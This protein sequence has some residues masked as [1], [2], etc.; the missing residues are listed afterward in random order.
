ML[1]MAWW[2]LKNKR[3]HTTNT[4]DCFSIFHVW[5]CLKFLPKLSKPVHLF[6]YFHTTSPTRKNILS[7]T[8]F[9]ELTS[10]SPS[11]LSIHKQHRHRLPSFLNVCSSCF[12]IIYSRYTFVLPIAHSACRMMPH[13][14]NLETSCFI[15]QQDIP[16]P[17]SWIQDSVYS[18]TVVSHLT[19]SQ[20]SNILHHF[21]PTFGWHVAVTISF[22]TCCNTFLLVLP[23]D[24]LKFVSF[25]II[26]VM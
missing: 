1:V 26:S 25:Q 10:P 7:W 5:D 16:R 11:L 20:P 12:C 23:P 9:G 15:Q 8:D 24:S 13:A 21:P 18:L 22:L 17:Q 6:P 14:P 3:Q 4:V 2:A 19:S